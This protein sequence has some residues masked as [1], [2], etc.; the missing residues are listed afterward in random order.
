MQ[1][2][3]EAGLLVPLYKKLDNTKIK[4]KF[5]ADPLRPYLKIR[6]RKQRTDV[7]KYSFVK[8]DH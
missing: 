3:K 4:L 7:G 6:T 8:R 2:E 1:V 5:Q